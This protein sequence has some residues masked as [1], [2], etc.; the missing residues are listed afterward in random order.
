MAFIEITAQI[1]VSE[2]SPERFADTAIAAYVHQQELYETWA[3][4]PQAY[5][6]A[7]HTVTIQIDIIENEDPLHAQ[8]RFTRFP[9]QIN[10]TAADED[11]ICYIKDT[12]FCRFYP[13]CELY[14][15]MCRDEEWGYL[16]HP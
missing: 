10:V 11:E 3:W 13:P 12:L 8:Q 15:S 2:F 7:G 14:S 5:G 16:W 6:P 4:I 1:Y 9:Y